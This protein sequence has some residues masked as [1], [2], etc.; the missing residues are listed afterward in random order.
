VILSI[1]TAATIC[2]CY[3]TVNILATEEGAAEASGEPSPCRGATMR[4]K[5]FSQPVKERRQFHI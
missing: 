3:T 1:V 2:D 5:E 4:G